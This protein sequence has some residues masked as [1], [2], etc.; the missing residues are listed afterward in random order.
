MIRRLALTAVLAALFVPAGARAKGDEVRLLETRGRQA[1][2][3]GRYAE[4]VTAFRAAYKLN[5][6]AKYH[7]NI[8]KAQ[9]KLAHYLDA[10]ESFQRYLLEAPDAPDRKDV[11]VTVKLVRQ[12]LA[13][14]KAELKVLTRPPGADLELKGPDGQRTGQTPYSTWLDFGEYELVV[15]ADGFET[16][17][18]TVRLEE[19]KPVHLEITMQEGDDPP[20]PPPPQIPN[21]EPEPEAPQGPQPAE[22]PPP[23]PPP[24]P[25]KPRSWFSKSRW[26]GLGTAGFGS[27]VMLWGLADLGNNNQP[28][29]TSLDGKV[30]ICGTQGD[31]WR[32]NETPGRAGILTGLLLVG[33]GGVLMWLDPWRKSRAGAGL[34]P[35]S[36]G[37]LV[38]MTGR[39]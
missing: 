2:A 31:R 6:Q 10:I 4:A 33:G 18:R 35:L 20:P 22:A 19:G 37:G 30:K 1:Y 25:R 9:E 5:A 14:V 27:L 23:P 15:S 12:K 39:F 24:P 29:A 16:A 28:V 11:E 7:Y 17:R 21:P 3:E 26:I 34:A 8:A 13:T 36:D 38:T 32:C